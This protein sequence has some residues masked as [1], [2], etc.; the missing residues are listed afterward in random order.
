[1]Q[2]LPHIHFFPWSL[3]LFFLLSKQISGWL[4]PIAVLKLFLHSSFLLSYTFSSVYLQRVITSLSMSS[5]AEPASENIRSLWGGKNSPRHSCLNQTFMFNPHSGYGICLESS[6]LWLQHFVPEG[7]DPNWRPV[8][9]ILQS[10]IYMAIPILQSIAWDSLIQKAA[11]CKST[12]STCSMENS[13]T[14]WQERESNVHA[15]LAYVRIE[16]ASFAFLNLASLCNISQLAAVS[17]EAFAA[18]WHVVNYSVV[19]GGVQYW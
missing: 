10:S 11:P 19:C 14:C 16:A 9:L 8:M 7:L 1:M 5:D 4:L 12:G 6:W 18:D 17:S 13:P 15:A 3:W 2:Y